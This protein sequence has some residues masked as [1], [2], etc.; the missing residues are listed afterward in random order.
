MYLPLERLKLSLRLYYYAEQSE[1]CTFAAV[2][3]PVLNALI[4][5][6]PLLYAA[7]IVAKSLDPEFVIP[8]IVKN[9]SEPLCTTTPFIAE[10][11]VFAVSF[12]VMNNSA[13]LYVEPLN[14]IM[15]VAVDVKFTELVSD[16]AIPPVANAVLSAPVIANILAALCGAEVNVMLVPDI[17]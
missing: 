2:T 6:V 3:P 13:L 14:V 17:V 10:N 1:Y 8:C 12:N 5:T 15:F 4:S 11:S 16:L 9:A 7:V